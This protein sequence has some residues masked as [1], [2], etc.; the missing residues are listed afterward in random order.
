MLDRKFILEN[1]ELVKKNCENRGVKAEVDEFVALEER[2]KKLQ[3]EVEELNRQANQVSKSIGQAKDPAE[4]EARKEE[5]RKLRDRTQAV[6]AE[7]DALGVEAEKLQRRIPNL[8]HPAAPSAS[9]TKRTS[10][11]FAAGRR[12]R[13][14][15]LS[16]SIMSS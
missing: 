8:S 1:V 6:Q 9:M 16:R 14:S 15:I 10:N 3:A 11:S 12:C 13:S 5:G 4:R 2:R 7:V